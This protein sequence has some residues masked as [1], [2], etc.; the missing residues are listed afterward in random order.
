MTIRTSEALA[1]DVTVDYLAVGNPTLDVRPDSS[2][3]VGGSVVYAVIQAARLGLSAA[4]FGRGCGRELEPVWTP[5]ETEAFLYVQSS[6]DTTRFRNE[7]TDSIRTQWLEKSAGAVSGLDRLPECR[8]LHLAPVAQEIVLDEAVRGSRRGLLGLTP[9]GLIRSWDGQGLVRHRSLEIDGPTAGSID[10]VVF[11]DYEAAYL[12]NVA[13]AVRRAG[14]I[15]VVTKGA[16]GC[17]VLLAHGTQEF[18]AIAATRL[19]D[20]TGAGDVFASSLFIALESGS[21]V[22]DAV[23]FAAAAATL[24]IEGIG[25]WAI[26]PRGEVLR[27]AGQDTTVAVS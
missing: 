25:P 11:A 18:P 4:G 17:E 14:G 23:R 8:V 22:S 6:A 15:V 24:S 26:A 16:R 2:L 1:S 5:S 27:L 3:A 7:N 12:S 10:V 9:Q 13:E 21:L 20:D 19:V